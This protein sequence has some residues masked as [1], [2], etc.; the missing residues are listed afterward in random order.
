MGSIFARKALV[1]GGWATDVRLRIEDGRIAG[2]E[3]GVRAAAEDDV[4]PIV[5][6]GLVNGHSHAFQRALAGRAEERSPAGEDS[7]WTWRE[8]MYELAARLDAAALAAIAA[9]AYGEM[10]A[11]GYTAVA[12]F[13]YLAGAAGNGDA[14]FEALTSAASQSGIRLC[15]VPVLYERAGFAAAGPEG[16]QSLF[17]LDLPNFLA[18]HERA[19]RRQ[20]ERIGVAIG[21]H[22]LRAV[23]EESLQELAAVARDTE[24]PL[25]LHVAEQRREVEDCIAATGCRPVEW[26]LEHCEVDAN[27]CLVHATHM[28]AVETA[29]LAG[30]GAVVCLCPSTEANLGDGL[31]PLR[32]FLAAGGTIAIGSDSQVSIDPFEELRWLE[33][34]QRLATG[35]RNIVALDHAHVGH[36]LFARVLAGGALAVGQRTAGLA[37]GACADL[38][39]LRDD[40][41]MLIGH[42][43]A[44]LLDALVFSGYPLPIERVMVHGEWCVIRGEHV[45]REEMLANFTRTLA[46]IGAAR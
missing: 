36:E 41:P 44:S 16:R 31:F 11:S 25:H 29:R 43:D 32:P 24:C 22:S 18:R 12:E 42:G 13:H 28:D 35:T 37:P 26:L 27:W 21:A 23:R 30:T 40:D 7:F 8:R 39:V 14:M 20:S 6:P 4:A 9:Q 3:S 1:A 2:I 19:R 5:I 10:L 38:V 33:Y 15:Y 34:G 17:A 46:R 45:R